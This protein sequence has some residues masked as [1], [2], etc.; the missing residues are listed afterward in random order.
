MHTS[1]LVIICTAAA[2]L[3]AAVSSGASA[4]TGSN[5]DGNSNKCLDT[6][7]QRNLTQ[8][9]VQQGGM[10]TASTFQFA[11]LIMF[12]W[13]LCG[14]K[15]VDFYYLPSKRVVPVFNPGNLT[16][17]KCHGSWRVVLNNTEA[18][19]DTYV[20]TRRGSKV[21]PTLR[22]RT[23]LRFVQSRKDLEAE[24]PS[25]MLTRYAPLFGFDPQSKIADAA[26]QWMDLW[27]T[28]RV[29]CG[30]QL[31]VKWREALHAL[32]GQPLST[33][34]PDTHACQRHNFTHVEETFNS[35]GDTL[36]PDADSSVKANIGFCECTITHTL[37]HHANFNS[38]SYKKVC[39]TSPL[40]DGTQLD[41]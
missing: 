30:S 26:R 33:M 16:I 17:I 5:E 37:D 34:E 4:Y 2:V 19:I 18:P 7:A 35:L 29:C 41:T 13:M 39:G 12:G 38:R 40:I 3:A 31:S 11:T 23:R 6:L 14:P 15:H 25:A 1:A 20:S 22:E 28:M 8:V 36:I 27:S 9:W 24:G 32:D 10:R 21:P